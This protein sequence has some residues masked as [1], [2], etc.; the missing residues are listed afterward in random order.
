MV[1][2]SLNIKT[3]SLYVIWKHKIKFGQN[4]FA[5]PKNMHSRTAMNGKYSEKR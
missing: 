2:F 3:G 1:Q 4:I 5:L